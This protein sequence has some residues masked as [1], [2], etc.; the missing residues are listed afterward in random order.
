MVARSGSPAPGTPGGVNFDSFLFQN[1]FN[2]AGQTGFFAYLTGS[3]VDHTNDNGIW[4]EASGSLA[5]VA[6][7]GSP[8]SG[9]GDTL[10]FREFFFPVAVN[11]SGQTLFSAWVNGDGVDETND[12]GIWIENSGTTALVVRSGSPAPGTPAGVKFAQFSL[13]PNAFYELNDA[14]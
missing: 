14:G 12:E 4:S 2:D 3:G 7:S 6:R 8:A 1:G 10:T 11:N 13:R 5:L 9:A